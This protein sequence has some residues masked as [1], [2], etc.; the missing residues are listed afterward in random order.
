[1][2]RLALIKET[3]TKHGL[4]MPKLAMPLRVILTGQAQTPSVDAGQKIFDEA[5][6]AQLKTNPHPMDKYRINCP[7]SRLELFRSIY[8]I[9]KGDKMYW[10]STDTIW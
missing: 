3:A 5:V 7:L 8:K 1:M 2:S 6:K 4:K 10:H 9:K